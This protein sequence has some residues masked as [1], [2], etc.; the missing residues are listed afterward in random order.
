MN[1]TESWELVLRAA[2]NFEMID[3]TESTVTGKR[4][5]PNLATALKKVAPRIERMRS[6]L[7]SARARKAG[8]PKCPRWAEA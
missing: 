3:E 4:L 1:L 7:D 5:M 2:R 6:R 8:K